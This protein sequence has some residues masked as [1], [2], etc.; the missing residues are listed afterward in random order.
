MDEICNALERSFKYSL[1][2]S[3]FFEV[4]V[5]IDYPLGQGLLQAVSRPNLDRLNSLHS[6]QLMV[7]GSRSTI[8][9]AL[10]V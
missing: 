8:N 3:V 1:N 5:K 10:N 7:Y 4:T 9:P 6:K 2:R